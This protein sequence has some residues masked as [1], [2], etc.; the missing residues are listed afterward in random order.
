[1]KRGVV[2]FA[3]NSGDIDYQSM[4][5]WS[6]DRIARHLGL[7]TTLITDVVPTDST[8]FED[9]VITTAESGGSRYF[10]DIGNNVIWFNGNRM[11]V[12]NLSPYDETLVL[13][14]DYVVCSDQLNLLF[15]ISPD[16]VGLDMFDSGNP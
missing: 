4:A 13:D 6:A 3:Y 2:I 10:S 15:E 11:D 7:P 14:A 12:Y 1:M 16:E 5:A 8:A 9:V